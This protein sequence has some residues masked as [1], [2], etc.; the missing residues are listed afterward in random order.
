M[1]LDG[2]INSSLGT[3]FHANAVL[4]RC[5]GAKSGQ[6]RTILLLTT[7]LD[8]QFVLIASAVGQE[9]NPA[10]Y[11]NLKSNPNCSLLVANRGEIACVAHEAE[12]EERAQAWA[13]ANEQFSGYT[14]YQ[15]KTKRR[16]PVMVLTPIS[17]V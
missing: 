7:P 4:L 15:G 16:I 3:N 6:A 11:Y 5:T 9:K 13:A 14:D 10:W 8:G 17:P 12:G 1:P 2:A